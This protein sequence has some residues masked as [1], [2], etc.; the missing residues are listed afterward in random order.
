MEQKKLQ[1]AS[2]TTETSEGSSGPKMADSLKNLFSAW[3]KDFFFIKRVRRGP[4]F[5]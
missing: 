2:E 1:L 4:K 5:F 3:N